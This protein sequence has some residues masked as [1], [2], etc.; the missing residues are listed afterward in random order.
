MRRRPSNV[1][2]EG[3]PVIGSSVTF[4]VSAGARVVIEDGAVVGDGTRMHVRAGELRVGAGTVLGERC[5]ILVHAGVE[6][7][8][9]CDLG[10]EVVLVD[11]GHRH[12]DVERPTREQALA[13]AP[14]RVGAGARIG[15]RAVI[16]R[17]VRIA[18]GGTV[19]AQTVLR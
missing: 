10:A 19:P 2:L 13:A 3:T 4:D 1:T 15:P 11:F 8:A 12:D 9:G 17:G 14:I 5:V 6:I 7:G 18:E 16:E